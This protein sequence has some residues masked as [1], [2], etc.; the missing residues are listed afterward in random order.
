MATA[1]LGL[2]LGAAPI[3]VLAF[4]VF[5][6]PLTQEYHAGRGAISFAFTLQNLA[7]ALFAPLTGRLIDRFGARKVI[8]PGT[9]IFG[10]MLLSSKL[11]GSKLLYFYIFL[12]ALGI[13]QGCTSPVSYSVVVSHWFN[14]RRGLG[15]GLMMLGIGVGAIVVP[16]AAQRLIAMFGWRA[17]YATCGGAVLV[18]VLPIA[19]AFLRNDPRDKGLLPDGIVD[20]NEKAQPVTGEHTCVE[21]LTWQQTWY[22][23]GCWSLRSFLRAEAYTHASCTCQRC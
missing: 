2:C 22:S 10:L 13:I 11:L 14:R 6:K 8:L 17:A 20:A 19:A 12:A 7:A 23:S 5:F 21:G 9:A 18:I 15:L 16:F 4:G 1:A 3:I